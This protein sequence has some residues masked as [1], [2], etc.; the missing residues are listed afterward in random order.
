[1]GSITVRFVRGDGRTF[2]AD[3]NTLGLVAASG[4]DEPAVEV[5]T[6][7]AAVGDGDLVTGQRV[8]S[9]V[10]DFTLKAR[11]CALNDV[12]RRAATSFFIPTQPYEIHVARP[13]ARR[14]AEGCRLESLCVPVDS[15]Y[16]PI[17]LKLAFLMPDGYFLS[18]DSF[19]KNIAG[20]DPLCG[21]PF[22]SPA[23]RGRVYGAF[24]FAQTV[25]LD[26][27]GD[28]P[29]YCQAVFVAQ[30]EV[31]NPKLIAGDG[32]VR[33]LTTLHS[34]DVLAVDGRTRSVS[35]NGENASAR[36]DRHSSFD[37]IV[38]APGTNAV[39]FTADIGANVLNVYVY[40]NKRY[41]GA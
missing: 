8:G 34:G 27:D 3:G 22:V 6:Q 20:V 10:L 30:G 5:F 36:L 38:F 12:L 17:T 29:A 9:R 16:R 21:Y 14:Y 24:A 32:Y 37:G 41:M 15:P 33:V 11:Q 28:A 25:Y 19:G 31:V 35:L 26:N 23:G 18:V 7:K 1:M 40:F 2:A 13:G 4:L 39:G